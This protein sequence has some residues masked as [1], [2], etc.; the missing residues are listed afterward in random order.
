MKG[1]NDNKLYVFLHG[2]YIFHYFSRD[3]LSNYYIY[4]LNNVV[5][6]FITWKRNLLAILALNFAKEVSEDQ[7]EE[8][9]V[10]LK[11]TQH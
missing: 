8:K 7:D 10:I 9:Y 4:F 2:I 5:A 11:N 6:L 1:L 3:V